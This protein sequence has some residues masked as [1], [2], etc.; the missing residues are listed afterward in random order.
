MDSS[1]KVLLGMTVGEI[2]E[3]VTG[4]LGMPGF[5]AGQIAR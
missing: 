5:T 4:T 1:K 3:L 2:K